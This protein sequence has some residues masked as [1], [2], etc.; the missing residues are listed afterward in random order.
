MLGATSRDLDLLGLGC[1]LGIQITWKQKTKNIPLPPGNSN[2]PS[3]LK[4]LDLGRVNSMSIAVRCLDSQLCPTLCDPMDWCLL[5]SSVHGIFLAW[6]LEWVAISS[7]R[8]SSWP[9]DWTHAIL[10]LHWPVDSLPLAPSGS[11]WVLLLPPR[12]G[13]NWLT[14]AS[15]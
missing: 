10:L 2:L 6:I 14:R 4:I 7:S 12:N 13:S 15:S 8:G 9:R 11:Q 3:E 1:G 5:V